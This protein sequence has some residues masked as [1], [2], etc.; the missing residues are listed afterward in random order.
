MGGWSFPTEAESQQGLQNDHRG[1]RRPV[2]DGGDRR[3]VGVE[4]L[5]SKKRFPWSPGCGFDISVLRRQFFRPP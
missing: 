5:T 2:G 1:D 4:S 3:V